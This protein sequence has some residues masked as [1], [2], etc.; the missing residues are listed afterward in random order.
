MYRIEKNSIKFSHN[1][2]EP[3]SRGLIE[4]FRSNNITELVFGWDFNHP[5]ENLPTGIKKIIFCSYY[6]DAPLD[7]LPHSIETIKLPKFYDHPVDNLPP[8]VKEIFFGEYFNQNLDY[9]PNNI[10][11]IYFPFTGRFNRK[12]LNL[13]DLLEILVLPRQYSKKLGYIPKNIKKI[14]VHL[15]Y[16]YYDELKKLVPKKE[17]LDFYI[18]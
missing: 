1:F 9:L 5:I 13:P 18:L 10:Q 8:S 6:Y 11:N 12:L 7:N 4:I 17:I 2:N 3:I 14:R 15:S 16:P